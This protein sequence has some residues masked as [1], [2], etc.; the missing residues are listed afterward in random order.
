M[1]IENELG[2]LNKD[3]THTYKIKA[4]WERLEIVCNFYYE[5]AYTNWMKHYWKGSNIGLS[6]GHHLNEYQDLIDSQYFKGRLVFGG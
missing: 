5:D 2:S 4:M 6:E 3:Y 1:Q